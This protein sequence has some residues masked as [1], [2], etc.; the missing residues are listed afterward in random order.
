MLESISV[1][2]SGLLRYAL[3]GKTAVGNNPWC[4]LSYSLAMKSINLALIPRLTVSPEMV[5]TLDKIF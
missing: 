1:Y 3:A 5:R 4:I 2:A